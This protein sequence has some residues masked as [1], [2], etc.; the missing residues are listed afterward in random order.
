MG[1]KKKVNWKG[2]AV[3]GAACASLVAY[4]TARGRP[5]V[6]AAILRIASSRLFGQ[7]GDPND[8]ELLRNFAI[9]EGGIF[10]EQMRQYAGEKVSVVSR[11]AQQ[12][13]RG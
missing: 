3:M 13:M 2:T 9:R 1:R 4:V 12:W 6:A 7:D 8:V 11:K 10:A 5:D